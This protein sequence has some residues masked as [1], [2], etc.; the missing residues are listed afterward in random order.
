MSLD[1]ELPSQPNVLRGAADHDAEHAGFHDP[2]HVAIEHA[3]VIGRQW[4]C[5]DLR[6][7]RGESDAL[8]SGELH[9]RSSD[10][11]EHIANVELRHLVAQ[12]GADVLD[13]EGNVRRAGRA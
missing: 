8:E 12:G 5:D 4:D 7:A 11:R 9:H 3:E 10:G 6:L 1:R 2:S 13:C